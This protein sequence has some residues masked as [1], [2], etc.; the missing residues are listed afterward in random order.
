M[1]ES[2]QI[3]SLIDSIIADRK[4]RANKL[5]AVRDKLDALIHALEYVRQKSI[6]YE[7]NVDEELSVVRQAEKCCDALTK[8]RY[9]CDRLIARWSKET[10]TV[11]VAGKARQGK[12]QLLQAITGLP[13]TILPASDGLP[14]TGARSRISVNKGETTAW[15][16]FLSKEEFL[17]GIVSEYYSEIGIG[18]SPQ[19]WEQFNASLPKLP[20]DVN[21]RQRN[22]YELLEQLH[23]SRN[24]FASLLSSQDL[25]ISPHEIVEY[26]SQ[27]ER[28]D[29]SKRR[30]YLAVRQ[31]DILTE[32]PNL[33]ECKLSVID[34]PG[35]GEI[36]RGHAAKLVDSL[37]KEADAILYVKLPP[38]TG[39]KWGE[40]DIAVF[41]CIDRAIPELPLE[42]Y[43]YLVLNERSDGKN[44]RLIDSLLKSLPQGTERC[45][46]YRVVALN[47]SA[48][49]DDLFL[50]LLKSLT[51]K[52]S[53]FD[54]H[55]L[56]A[57]RES[58]SKAVSTVRPLIELLQRESE[59]SGDGGAIRYN[60]LKNHFLKKLRNEIEQLLKHFYPRSEE[61]AG[62]ERSEKLVEDLERALNDA[63]TAVKKEPPL[64]SE[65]E[66]EARKNDKGGWPGVVQDELHSIRSYFTL[67]LAEEIESRIN[68]ILGD[69]R[70]ETVEL[71]TNGELS[72]LTDGATVDLRLRELTEIASK[73]RAERIERGLQFIARMGISYHSQ[74]H[75]SIRQQLTS[76]DPM[77]RFNSAGEIAPANE[78][79]RS[80]STIVKALKSEWEEVCYRVESPLRK[81]CDSI[82][83]GVFAA[84]EECKDR[85][86]RSEGV[87][88]EWDRILYPR[89]HR[90]WKNEYE[91]IR[92]KMEWASLCRSFAESIQSVLSGIEGSGYSD[93][94]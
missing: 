49:R 67:R 72:G 57:C 37:E 64:F 2:Q 38:D 62:G 61:Q 43:L 48:V 21:Q 23:A 90:I 69:I 33:A 19:S 85:L 76:L 15:V 20:D 42:S 53:T 50:P 31:V 74:I 84:L 82:P 29:G 47:H 79:H 7:N 4:E 56:T 36:A 63:L 77:S 60:P 24:S 83:W 65:S 80:A 86:V 87:D 35:L 52:I 40:D 26:V 10:I 58:I 11:G 73:E 32:F 18:T 13:N 93:I 17:R 5:A 45:D 8:S 81:T 22:Q 16:S 71:L 55:L 68:K 94:V 30:A 46:V 88:S 6:P 54:S 44:A 27:S 70:E 34:L 28:D 59:V 25:Q 3:P 66:L 75:P 78:P 91:E 51:S 92:S 12:S 41:D 39:D 9:Q 14:T 1:T 89:R